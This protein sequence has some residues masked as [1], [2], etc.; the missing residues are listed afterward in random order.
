[1]IRKFFRCLLLLNF[2]FWGFSFQLQSQDLSG[3]NRE[4]TSGESRQSSIVN[5]LSFNGYTTHWNNYYTEWHR[6]G[7]LFKTAIPEIRSTILQ[8]KID[9]AEDMGMPG[10]LIQEGF[11]TQLTSNNYSTLDNPSMQE[12]ENS[13]K[14]GNLLVITDSSTEVG[15]FLEAKAG[16]L[17]GWAEELNSYQYNDVN[18]EPVKAFYLY[19]GRNYLFVISSSFRNQVDRFHTLLETTRDLMQQYKIHKG[20]LGISTNLKAVTCAPGHPIELIGKGM[21][22]GVSWF[23]FD[24]YMARHGREELEEWV[25]ESKLPIVSDVGNSPIYACTDYDDLQVQDMAT[26]QAW[27]DYARKKGGYAFRPVYDPA[28]DAFEFD[29]YFAHP[30]NKEQIDNENVPF[31]NRAGGLSSDMTSSM[32]LFIEQNAPLSNESIWKAI[33]EREAVAVSGNAFMMGPSKFRNALQLLYLDK[34]FLEE[35]FLDYLDM[36]TEMDGYNLII[37]MTNYSTEPVTGK[38]DITSSSSIEVKSVVPN[39]ITLQSGE[40]KQFRV[41]LQPGIGAMGRTNPVVTQFL[42]GKNKKNTVTLLDLPPVISMHQLLYG[43]SPEVDYP[44]TIHNFKEK[45]FFPVEVVVVEKQNPKKEVFRHKETC[46]IPTATYKEL[47]FQLR[48]DPGDY[49][50]KSS[51]LGATSESQLGVGKAEGQPY[52]YEVDLNS[53]GINEFRME[54]DSVQV[55]LLRTGARVIE[56]IVKSKND[57]ILYKAWPEVTYNHKRPYRMRGYYPYGGFEDFLGQASMETHRIYDAKI[58]QKEG[59]YVQV[60]METNYYG[61]KL[62]KIFTLYGNSPLLEVKFALDFINPEANVLGPQPILELGKNHGT[63][64]LFTVPTMDGLVEYR[65]RQEDYYG[66]AINLKEGWNAG[67]DTKEDITF[68]GAFPVSQPIFLHMWMNHPRNPDAPHYYVEFQPWTPIIQKST[69]YFSYYLWGSAG[70]W[71]NGLDELKKR[72]LISIRE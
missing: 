8:S 65:M 20:W 12:L 43:H 35:Y 13:S 23:I 64:D 51:A 36:E 34:Y 27:I 70:K 47:T 30:G 29:G 58:I 50:V 2:I 6:Y 39:A 17:F 38:I 7:N 44:V 61:N 72:N 28:S 42:W 71:Q 11:Y 21:N 46:E 41:P 55:T 57:N 15:Q 14:N 49:I 22:E 60:E 18:L 59:D 33:M 40:T 26:K 52:L 54:N 66:A 67:Y 16:N 53:D 56:Y 32:V 25:K 31:I 48:L 24:G 3:F 9:V 62:K 68:V 69:M 10:L 4:E 5:N 45:K 63:E 19:N 37:T 1:M